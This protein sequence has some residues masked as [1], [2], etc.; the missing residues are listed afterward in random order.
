MN[1]KTLRFDDIVV[2]KKEFYKCK[3]LINLDLGNVYQMAISSKF[4]HNHDD[5]KYFTGYTEGDIVKPLC[6]I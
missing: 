6:I 4:K 3:Q 2:S 1:E 5:F